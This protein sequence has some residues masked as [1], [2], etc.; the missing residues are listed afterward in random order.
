MSDPWRRLLAAGQA[1]AG[2]ELRGLTTYKLGGP[3]AYFVEAND[4]STLAATAEAL[5]VSPLPVLILG[6]GS[7]LVIADDGFPGV[8]IR[9]GRRFAGI[10]TG[11]VV[12]AGGAAGLPQVARTATAASRR[13]VE[14]MIGIPGTVGGGVRQNA[15]CFGSEMVDVLE[16]AD[17]FD[18]GRGETSR[19]GA[20][21]LAMAYR[22]TNL[23]STQIVLEARF[24]TEG[25]DPDEGAAR[26]REI[27]RWRRLHQPGG[28]LNA[29]S[30]FK[31]PPGDSAGRII[32]SLGLKGT[33]VGGASVSEKHANFFVAM[34]GTKASEVY[35]L[36]E[37]VREAVKVR[38]GIDLEPE[39][40]FAGRF[41][42]RGE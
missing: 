6:R 27:T 28:T 32:D 13:G 40:Q 29:G 7:N 4:P 19:V 9:L 24:R 41:A 36:V 18:L 16:T 17:L 1:H 37:K 20:G 14:F 12:T 21:D 23:A 22:Q 42:D 15:G 35:L 33:A 34:P 38:T 25:G 30:V 31:N 11:E 26:I 8:V 2:V 10:E 3:A 39:I 5:A